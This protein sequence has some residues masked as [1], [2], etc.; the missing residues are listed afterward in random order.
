MASPA[1]SWSLDWN[2]SSSILLYASSRVLPWVSAP[3]LAISMAL[4]PWQA[5]TASTRACDPG[6]QYL[7]VGTLPRR[8]TPSGVRLLLMSSPFTASAVQ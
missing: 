8:R 3:C 7:T 5:A 6:V 2:S 1:S 4:D